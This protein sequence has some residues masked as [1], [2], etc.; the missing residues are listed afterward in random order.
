GS[1]SSIA[2]AM[3]SGLP[4]IFAPFCPVEGVVAVAY[5][6]FDAIMTES[7]VNLSFLYFSASYG[8][9]DLELVTRQSYEV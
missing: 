1:T 6:I 9:T 2:L 8:Q 4:N 3:G 7:G 5:H